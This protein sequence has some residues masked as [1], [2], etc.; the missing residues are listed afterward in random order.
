MPNTS[1]HSALAGARDA[2]PVGL[3]YIPL[4]MGMGM[5]LTA[6]GLEWWWA[7]IFA[8]FMYAGSMQYLIVPMIVAH[9]SFA[10][11]AVAT[12]LIQ[13]R[14]VFYG[15]S[16]PLDLVKNK[17]VKLY[18]IHAITD[19]VYAVIASK[20]REELTGERVIW[21]QIFSHATW[22]TGCTLGAI[23][24]LAVPIDARILNFVL[25]SLFVVLM[26]EAY[27]ANRARLDFA[28]AALIGVALLL[29][30]SS[31]YLP[32]ALSVLTLTLLIASRLSPLAIMPQTLKRARRDGMP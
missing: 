25:T 13:F 3:G 27:L 2:I 19:E 8:L 24:G 7:P 16:F 1:T 5:T 21:T 15:I 29:L 31:I 26:L 14:H 4:G 28:C 22:I 30:P 23:V 32:S 9:E 6:A 11:I 20:P 17:L 18:S 12:L 10:A